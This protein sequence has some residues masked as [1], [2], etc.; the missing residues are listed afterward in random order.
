M[1]KPRLGMVIR[2]LRLV[3]NY[4]GHALQMRKPRLGMVI[5]LLR[6]VPNYVGHSS[7]SWVCRSMLPPQARLQPADRKAEMRGRERRALKTQSRLANIAMVF[8]VTSH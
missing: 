4:V 7:Y 8:P 3:P 1:R 2:L 5:R 6:L